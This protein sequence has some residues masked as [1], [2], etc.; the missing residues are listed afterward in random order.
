MPFFKK[1]Y[2]CF[3]VLRCL[4]PFLRQ[5]PPLLW[6]TEKPVALVCSGSEE[7]RASRVSRG[8]AL[9]VRLD[10]RRATSP[11][12]GRTQCTA[13]RSGGGGKRRNVTCRQFTR[14]SFPSIHFTSASQLLAHKLSR[15]TYAST[16]RSVWTGERGSCGMRARSVEN[17]RRRA[18][19]SF[20][21][22]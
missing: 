4:F 6:K 14:T 16:Y 19:A 17:E 2:L 10:R 20:A 1:I 12:G 21:L 18:E 15:Y 13:C 3:H 22:S 8:S 7:R 9:S 11:A 5:P